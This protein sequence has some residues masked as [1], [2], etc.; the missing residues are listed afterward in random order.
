MERQKIHIIIA[1]FL[2][3]IVW[4]STYYFMGVA[5]RDFPPFLLGAFHFTTAGLILLLYS[6]YQKEP[7]FKKRLIKKSAISGIVL[8]FIDMAVVIHPLRCHF[9]RYDTGKRRCNMDTNSRL[10]RNAI[11]CD[12][13]KQ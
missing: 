12:D 6:W 3:Y 2:I 10:D 4:G 7:V 5:L 8:L 1:Y 13:D 9:S 11:E